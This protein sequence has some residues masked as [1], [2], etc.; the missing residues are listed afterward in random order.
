MSD[1]VRPHRRQ[2]TRLPHPWDSQARTL[3]WVAISFSNAGKW[4]VKVKSLSRVQ[5]LATPWTAACQAPPPMGFS[6]Q[7][8]W[9]GVPLPSTLTLYSLVKIILLSVSMN[10]TFLNTFI[11]KT[12]FV[13]WSVLSF[14]RI[15]LSRF[16]YIIA[17]VRSIHFILRQNTIVLNMYIIF[18]IHLSIS[19]H[20]GWFH[21]L[22]TISNA[23]KRL[24]FQASALKLGRV[25]LD[26]N[27]TL[28]LILCLL[29]ENKLCYSIVFI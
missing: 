4:K 20:L 9:N 22:V 27:C 6:R 3:E 21:F 11:N 19:G 25:L 18:L 24:S 23:G 26:G 28:M 15:R 10:L 7:E 2:P 8:Y 5:L 29:L 16:L 17:C 13:L 1:S 14:K 12:I